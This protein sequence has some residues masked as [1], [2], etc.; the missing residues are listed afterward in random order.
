M[1]KATIKVTLLIDDD[2]VKELTKQGY[3][4]KDIARA[5]TTSIR[6]KDIPFNKPVYD[7][8]SIELL[9]YY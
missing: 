1:N 6:L 9:K 8:E 4:D 2:K 5:I 3:S 7:I